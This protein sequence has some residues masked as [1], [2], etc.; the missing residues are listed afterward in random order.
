[1][2]ANY[3]VGVIAS[4]RIA[5]E[6]GRGWSECENTEIA[7]I[8]D[9]HPEALESY[10]KDFNVK[11][12]YL[13]YREMIAKENLDIVSVCSWDP[14]HAE[15]T[16]A[17]AAGKPQAIICEKPMAVS[18]GEG[19]AMVIACQ[20]NDVKLAIGHQRRF[21]SSWT[22]A[23][24]LIADGALGEPKRLWTGVRAG[25]MNTGTHGIDFQQ[26]AL[27]DCGAE[28]VMGAVE[29]KTDH[30][31]FGHRVEDRCMGLIGY[32][33]GAVGVIENELSGDY[34]VGA[35]IYGSDGMMEVMDNSL[36]YMT[37][38][39]SGWLEFEPT[40]KNARGYGNAFVDQA[41]AIV[42]WVEGKVDHYRG[43]AEHGKAALEIM[44]AV[45]ESARMHERVSLPLQTRA[46]P[47]DVAVEEGKI[48]V[49]RPGWWDERSFLVRGEGMSWMGGRS[50]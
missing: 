50:T 31:I 44:M 23:R 49:E 41:Y 11:S 19:E 7:A 25:M 14:Q 21:Y 28:W 16:I 37:Q 45:Y 6:H 2:A 39:T 48:P 12:T 5:R 36:K 13:D 34:M 8:S 17:A 26:Y 20:R 15:M 33:N 4:G 10:A 22:E 42:E 3:R 1:M 38:A 27:G 40:D 43:D 46:N 35:T 32:K 24:R 18:L 29:R 30:H 47:L 9:S